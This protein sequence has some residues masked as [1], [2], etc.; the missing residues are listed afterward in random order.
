MEPAC[1]S[2]QYQAPPSRNQPV[3]IAPEPENAYHEP[4]TT[5]H[6]VAME[7]EASSQYSAPPS[8]SQPVRIAQVSGSSQ[9]QTPRSQTQP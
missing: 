9:Y 6:P 1:G 3:R 5:R 8:S 7:P 4:S 2:S